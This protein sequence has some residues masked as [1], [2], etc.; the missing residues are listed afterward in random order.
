M[1]ITWKT[2]AA[3]DF[4]SSSGMLARAGNAFESALQSVGGIVKQQEGIIA[5]ERAQNTQQAI[6]QIAG[7]KNIEDYNNTSM[8]D[9]V[10]KFGTN[11]N[12]EEVFNAFESRDDE[13]YKEQG[14]AYNRLIQTDTRT[15]LNNLDAYISEGMTSG[16]TQEELKAGLDVLLADK[17]TEVRIAARNH[18]L[19]T[20]SFENDL[21][22]EGKVMYEAGLKSLDSK[23]NVQMQNLDD[24]LM[25]QE[26]IVGMDPLKGTTELRS[27]MS[28]VDYINTHAPDTFWGSFSW[29]DFLG[30]AYEGQD[31]TSLV[32]KVKSDKATV[33]EMQ[34][35]LIAAG[36]PEKEVKKYRTIPEDVFKHVVM[37]AIRTGDKELRLGSTSEF[38][39]KIAETAATYY[40]YQK[41]A[42]VAKSNIRKLRSER[43]GLAERQAKDTVKLRNNVK[44]Y[45]SAEN[46]LLGN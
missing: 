10:M 7:I 27:Q 6:E 8:N 31:I 16:K 32:N 36:I 42:V 30:G 4:S 40:A 33:Q 20:M 24:Q 12:R 14:E 21:T 25:D 26:A 39:K 34:S 29:P 19:D 9:L 17:P 15:T 44:N 1:A 45:R 11:I 35:Q 37:T 13:I 38:R 46:K 2:I 5:D 43:V 28:L 23:Y 3:P 22:P 18:F 41:D